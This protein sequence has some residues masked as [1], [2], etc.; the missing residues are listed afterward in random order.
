MYNVAVMVNVIFLDIDGVLNHGHFG[1][2]ENDKFGFA[3]DCIQNLKKVLVKVP[4]TKL[5]IA[6]SWKHFTKQGFV[7]KDTN[8]WRET[9]CKKLGMSSDV[10]LGD[11]PDLP[12]A[13]R[14]WE[15]NAWLS[16]NKTKVGLGT[17]AILDDEC[18]SLRDM[19]PNNVVDCDIKT[20]EGLSERKANEAIWILSGFKHDK[21]DVQHWLTSDTH[22]FHANII[23]YC[24]RP[25]VDV[26][27]MNAVL[28]ERWNSIVGQNDIVH[29]LGDFCFGKK[30][31]VL[32]ILPKLN[33]KID[34]VLG[35]HDRHKI[36][37]YYE[38]GFH[39]VYDRPVVLRNFFILSH[40]PLEWI[41]NDG[42]YAN[43]FGHVHDST[44][45]KTV[46]SRS[47]CAC[48]ERWDYKPIKWEDAVAAMERQEKLESMQMQ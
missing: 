15:I 13:D 21:T 17:F 38:A 30:E 5:V 35:N 4:N 8:D 36:G 27:E 33:G 31:N 29:H 6:S 42:P 43:F 1:K 45:Y 34:I 40:A 20:G 14:S 22:F 3:D 37:F 12:D 19:F 39:R 23:K 11:T 28:V 10:I 9:L 48:V 44:V 47:V 46:T 41:S 16:S 32:E 2:D 26:D 25:F 7:D 24:N 18:I